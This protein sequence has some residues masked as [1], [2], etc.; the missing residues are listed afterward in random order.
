MA[1]ETARP[2][3]FS[4][5]SL[6]VILKNAV[7]SS[8]EAGSSLSVRTRRVFTEAKSSGPVAP[9]SILQALRP[10]PP[11]GETSPTVT[12]PAGVPPIVGGAFG[13]MTSMLKLSRADDAWPWK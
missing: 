10:V 5:G 1:F 7:A 4:S 9:S 3:F 2:T 12:E 8:F 13:R 11:S 6:S